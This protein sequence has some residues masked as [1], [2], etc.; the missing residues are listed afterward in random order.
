MFFQHSSEKKKKAKPSG[1][2]C[3]EW[4]LMRLN[5][6]WL[7]GISSAQQKKPLTGEENQTISVRR[8]ARRLIQPAPVPTKPG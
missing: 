2:S 1:A 7:A 5:G 6:A 4:I 3:C 8:D